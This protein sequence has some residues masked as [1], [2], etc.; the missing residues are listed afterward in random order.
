LDATHILDVFAEQEVDRIYLNFSD[1]WPRKK[2]ADKRLTTKPY[3]DKY[4]Q[5]LK[6]GGSIHFKTDNE[7]LFEFSLNTL[8]DAGWRLRSI[9]FDLHNSPFQED[10]IMTEYEERYVKQGRPIYRLEAF[11]PTV[12]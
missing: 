3:L 12:Q 1:P 11:C 6:P 2:H 9:T 8:S 5:I 10:N 4:M 7:S